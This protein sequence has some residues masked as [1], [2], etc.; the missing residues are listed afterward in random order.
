MIKNFWNDSN[1]FCLGFC[2]AVMLA[3][4]IRGVNLGPVK[5]IWLVWDMMNL[6]FNMSSVRCT[7]GDVHYVVCNSVAVSRAISKFKLNKTKQNKKQWLDWPRQICIIWQDIYIY[8]IYI[9]WQEPSQ[10]SDESQVFFCVCVLT[11][12]C[13]VRKCKL[14]FLLLL[15]FSPQNS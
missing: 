14:L 2:Q 4:K 9:I 3:T 8:N 15:F 5:D 1:S 11:C 6:A 10:W 12:V 13:L 7:R